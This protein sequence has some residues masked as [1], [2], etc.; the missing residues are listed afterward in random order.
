MGTQGGLQVPDSPDE[1]V[2]VVLSPTG[3]ASDDE[4]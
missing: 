1:G 2:A 3:L 4:T